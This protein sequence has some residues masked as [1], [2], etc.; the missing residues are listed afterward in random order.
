MMFKRRFLL[1]LL[2]AGAL[3]GAASFEKDVLERFMTSMYGVPQEKMYVHTDKSV[4]VVG[5]R[6]WWRAYLVDPRGYD[7]RVLSRFVYVELVDRRDSLVTRVKVGERGDT[8]C[9]HGYLPLSPSLPSG[10]YCLRGYSYYMQNDGEGCL[11]TKRLRVVNPREKSVQVEASAGETRG[12]KRVVSARF[13][14]AL[15]VPYNKAFLAYETTP[16]GSDFS[17]SAARADEN[18]EMSIRVD[19]AVKYVTFHFQDN[20][21]LSFTRT[22]FLPR[23]GRKADVQFFPEGGTLLTGN[24]QRV[25]FKA[26]GEDGLPVDVEGEVYQDTTL[27]ATFAPVHDGMGMFRLPVSPGHRYSVVTRLPTGEEQRQELPV[28]SRTGFGVTTATVDD[29]VLVYRVIKGDE[30]VFPDDLHLF[31]HAS[32]HVMGI[33]HVSR[34]FKGMMDLKQFPEGIAHVTLVDGKGRVYSERLVFARSTEC[35]RARIVP[36]KSVY[37]TRERVTLDL[38]LPAGEEGSFSLAV[39]DD[40]HVLVDTLE[41]NILSNLLLT[42]EVKGH[43]HAPAYYF[44]DAPG[45][46]EALDLVMMTH[47]W[48][49]F[50]LP[51]ILQEK[52]T[53]RPYPIERGQVVSGR[54]DNFWGKRSRSANIILVSTSGITRTGETDDKGN[55]SIDVAYPDSTRFVLQALSEKGR[56]RVVAVIDE[57]AFLPPRYTLPGTPRVTREQE[58]MLT[59]ERE[60][61]YYYENGERVYVLNE[62]VVS[63]RKR[64]KYNSF[65]DQQARHYADSAA[66]AAVWSFDAVQT[67]QHLFPGVMLERD[68]NGDEYFSYIN[69]RMYLLMNDFEESI[70][71]LHMIHPEALLSIS[72][73][74]GRQGTMYFGE[75]ASGGVINVSYKFGFIPS[76]PGRP[77][78][79]PFTLLG[80]Q[81]AAEFYVPKYEVDSVR[82]TLEHDS[83]R[84]IYW[85]PAVKLSGEKREKLS[86]YTAD[87]PGSYSIVLEGITSGGRICRER[88]KLVVKERGVTEREKKRPVRER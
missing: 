32:G 77:N 30:A 56:R 1:L 11:F 73:L 22:V 48:K 82:L 9:F 18:G 81:K 47:G 13:T 8:A 44:S 36:D 12:G 6:V 51:T 58:K 74:D 46:R 16:K 23:A 21:P 76:S 7:W 29:S 28:P 25:A 55:F 49:R 24:W 43:V 65:Y 50:D 45:A 86:F 17:K 42:S 79:V 84:T 64:L 35:P 19:T 39:T 75:R 57:D 88:H 83:R 71:F 10:D 37:T 70:D 72:M 14:D 31:V 87:T 80:Y 34:P 54:V 20:E 15:D 26:I 52:K 60:L 59:R 69:Q 53:E 63:R 67:I 40:S 2:T 38:D 4:Y 85:N 78:I 62:V 66:I 5:E 68:E 41:D 27:I 33:E 3:V 61:N